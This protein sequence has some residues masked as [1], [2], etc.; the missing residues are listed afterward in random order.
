MREVMSHKKSTFDRTSLRNQVKAKKKFK[1][2]ATEMAVES[3]SS[4]QLAIYNNKQ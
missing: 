4:I 1:I 2:A 3:K